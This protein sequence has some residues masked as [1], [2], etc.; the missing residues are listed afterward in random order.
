MRPTLF[1][2]LLSLDLDFTTK[3]LIDTG[4]PRCVFP[5]G[6]A[7]ALDLPCPMLYEAPTRV[8]LM[9][10][11]WPAV[12]HTVTFELQPFPDLG[13]EAEVDFVLEEGLPF[14]LLGYEGFLNRWAVTFNA[15]LGYFVIEPA[16]EFH[17]RIPPDPYDELQRY[18]PD[19]FEP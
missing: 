19:E 4:A 11:E 18:F 8:L 9:G 7:D 16:E 6:A 17:R 12:T 2:K 14:G 3:A 13:W 15:A 1:V 5:R 10:H